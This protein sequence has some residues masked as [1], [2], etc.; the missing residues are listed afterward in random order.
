MSDLPPYVALLRD[1]AAL[2]ADLR[3]LETRILVWM[4]DAG[5]TDEA[6]SDVLN[7]TPQQVGNRR[8]R[9]V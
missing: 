3:R 1:L 8:R 6:M 7:I 4:R 9:K 2:Q 5:I